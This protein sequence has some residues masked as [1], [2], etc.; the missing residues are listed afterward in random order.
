MVNGKEID[1]CKNGKLLGLNI[2]STGFNG[3]IS[4]TINKGKGILSQ[5]RRFRNLTPNMKQKLKWK[6]KKKKKR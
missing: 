2:T 6:E 1:T 5:L 3:H 4:K